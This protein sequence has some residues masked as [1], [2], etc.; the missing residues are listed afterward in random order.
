MNGFWWIM[1]LEML[2]VVAFFQGIWEIIRAVRPR[3]INCTYT[4]V[5]RLIVRIKPSLKCVVSNKIIA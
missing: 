3:R 1:R 2:F 5:L 4:E